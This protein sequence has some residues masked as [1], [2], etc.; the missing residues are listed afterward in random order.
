MMNNAVLAAKLFSIRNQYGKESA[1]EKLKLLQEINIKNVRNKKAVQSLYTTLL[2]L[3][4]WPD[5][6]KIYKAA[7]ELLMQLHQQV[8]QNET[9]QYNLYN[10]GL[11]GTA[12]CAAFSFEMVKW[13]RQKK[14]A[15]IKFNSFEAG[16][17]QVQA[18]LSVIMSKA[19]SEIFQDGNAEW[20]SWLKDLRMPGEDILDQLIAIFDSTDIRPEVKDE[21][22]NAIGINVE[23]KLASHCSLPVS[24]TKTT[25]YHRSLFK[26]NSNKQFLKPIAVKLGDAEAEQIIDCS[27]MILIRHLREI[28]PTSFTDVKLVS[29]YHLQRGFSVA[30]MEMVPERRHP[31]DSYMS[32]TVF[33][34]GLPVAYGGCWILFDSGR[35]GLNVFPDYRGGETKY[36]FNQLLQLHTYV[37]KLKRFTVDPYQ[38]GKDNSDGIYSG[39]FWIYYQAGFR[40]IEKRQQQIAEAEAAKITADKKYRSSPAVLKV[41]AQSRLELILQ[42]SAAGFDAT[43]LS[44]VYANIITKKFKGSRLLAEKNAAKKLAS[45]LQIKNYQD[46]NINFVLKN[47][48]LFLL[49]N[50]EGLGKSSDLKRSLK[51]IF[52]LKANGSEEAYIL[53][54]QKNK[55][56]YKMMNDL[57]KKYAIETQ[58]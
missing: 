29:Y 30:L 32:Y 15:D 48:A 33:K 58:L 11:T 8:E 38:I 10:S 52:S 31:I 55:H 40:P 3:Q 4:A 45:I 53:A 18:F 24:L 46:D 56:L 41:L 57:V 49:C 14:A 22:W 7:Q 9:L 26:K 50:E 28:D 51:H 44:R 37:Y 19:E 13:L 17:D 12:I 21:I 1:I 34:N 2:F 5:D 27:R 6:K 25:F 23:I 36:I 47:W 20:K 43:D 35:I 54:S 42:K 16:D 39:S